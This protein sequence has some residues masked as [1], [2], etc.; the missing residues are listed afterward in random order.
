MRISESEIARLLSLI[1]ERPGRRS[2]PIEGDEQFT[3]MDEW[4]DGGALR[5]VTG[6]TEYHFS[7]GSSAR[8]AV[9]PQ[10]LQVTVTFADGRSLV[11][12]QR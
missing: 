4:F 10:S 3:G 11:I 9:A 2:T 6:S 1:A 7:D 12:S 5:Y 8:V